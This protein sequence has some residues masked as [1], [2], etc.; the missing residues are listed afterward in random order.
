MPIGLV[1]IVLVTRFLPK[2]EEHG[3][4]PID[5]TGFFL[6]AVAFCGFVFGMSV[7]SLPAL[8]IDWGYAT[9]AAGVLP[10]CSICATPGARRIRCSTRR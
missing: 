3:A 10:G 2:G 4:R 7:V 8:P 9:V 6:S 5:I 1:G